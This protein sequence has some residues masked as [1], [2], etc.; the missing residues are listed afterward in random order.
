MTFVKRNE[1]DFVDILETV[2]QLFQQSPRSCCHF[3]VLC[4]LLLKRCLLY[5]VS[6]YIDE[7]GQ[8]VMSNNHLINCLFKVSKTTL[9]LLSNKSKFEDYPDV[10]EDYFELIVQ[11]IKHFPQLF[12]QNTSLVETIFTRGLDGL[13]IQHDK[14]LQSIC[15]FYTCFIALARVLLDR[16]EDSQRSERFAIDMTEA[17]SSVNPKSS[18]TAIETIKKGEFV[19]KLLRDHGRQLV[20]QILKGLMYEVFQP[21]VSHLEQILEQ[22]FQLDKNMLCD[23]MTYCLKQL[24]N[25][26][27]KLKIHPHKNFSKDILYQ[28]DD[29]NVKIVCLIFGRPQSDICCEQNISFLFLNY[30]QNCARLE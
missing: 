22:M 3:L 11:F 17:T 20:L 12:L 18:S 25:L 2:T 7:Y 15:R 6:V 8:S 14:A 4:A 30:F 23:F 27:Y 5:V 24:M 9:T 1:K 26:M 21:S 16:R 29:K 13:L 19:C 28:K 10:V